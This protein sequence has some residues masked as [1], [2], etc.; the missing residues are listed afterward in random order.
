MKQLFTLLLAILLPLFS[1]A[2]DS[3]TCG[4]G[5]T[6][7]YEENTQTLSITGNGAMSDY[8]SYNSSNKKAAPWYAYRTDIRTIIV[9]EGATNIGN[10]A[11]YGCSS[12]TSIEIPITVSSIGSNA[13]FG[14]SGLTAISIPESVT[15]I[16]QYAFSDC[17]GLTSVTIPEGVTE[18][19]SSAF[20]GCTALTSITIPE[21]VTVIG[22]SAF[23]GCTALKSIAIPEGVTRIKSYTF[24]NCQNLETVYLPTS[25]T[26]IEYLAF[27]VEEGYYK[28]G[29]QCLPY[30]R[31]IY[32]SAPKCPTV[33]KDQRYYV[34]AN[35]WSEEKV[36]YDAYMFGI[37]QSNGVTLHVPSKAIPIYSQRNV[38]NSCRYI[39]PMDHAIKYIVDGEI[40]KC[41][42]LLYLSN[43]NPESLPTKEGYTFSGWH[44]LPETMPDNDV[45]VKGSFSVN[46][47]SLIYKI[48]NEAYKTMNIAYGT[49]LTQE[50]QPTKEGY[51]F[52]GWDEIPTTMPA[53]DVVITGSFTVNT[54][55]LIY[56]VDGEDYASSQQTYGSVIIPKE[57]PM[58]EGYT[59]IGWSDLPA[60]MPASD[61]VVTGSF[62]INTYTL[63]YKVDGLDYYSLEVTYGNEL[64]PMTAPVKE[65]YTFSGWNEV[66]E[67]MPAHD[68]TIT[69][70]FTINKYILTYEVDGKEYESY[71]L[72]YGSTIFPVPA[73]IKEG[74]TFSG[75]SEIPEEMPAHD[76]VITG[77]FSVNSYTLTYKVDGEVYK[78]ESIA[79]GTELTREVE[80]AKEGYTFLGWSEIPATMPAHDVVITGTF[81]VNSYT[82]TYKVDGEEYKTATVAYGTVL[83]AE[84]APTREGYTFSGWSEFPTT[85]PAHD[86]EVIGT[87]TVNSYTVT[88]KYADEVVTT[89]SVEYGTEI[90]LPESLGSERYT[91]VEWLGVPATMPAYDITIQA[92]F[93]D[94]VKDVQS[95]NLDA[96][97]YRLNGVKHEKL[98]RGL[99]IVRMN[100][101]TTRK[102]MVK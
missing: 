67:T 13:F 59:F 49:E 78:T 99:N 72:K 53:H 31:D 86:V 47:Y 26:S 21:G 35:G 15:K 34:V 2:D 51:T 29:Y 18:I 63:T 50:D 44:G 42:T 30:L 95:N 100:D 5:L 23:S 73:P 61:V 54:Y 91:L 8:S 12:L 28:N 94:G 39:V 9:A 11:F 75:W 16:L 66:P 17:I 43:I 57:T 64:I 101:G 6:Y 3:G 80:P 48:D 32:C 45:E 68:V 76:V 25:I 20:S 87:F 69:G 19:G 46:T 55:Q 96:E 27:A 81:A 40:Y 82:L 74:Y 102:V 92:S 97:Y 93:T 22:S 56:K 58:K 24:F 37:V 33:T 14:C 85:M 41:D 52:S 10:C 83:T 7:T 84:T 38:W 98:Q 90:P 77:S 36:Y 88:F 65:G 4:K 1:Y 71:T 62:S 70:S 79:Y 60:T 89:E